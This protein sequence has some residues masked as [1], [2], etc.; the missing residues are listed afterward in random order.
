[1]TQRRLCC[2]LISDTKL[3]YSVGQGA[4]LINL[5][6]EHTFKLIPICPADVPAFGFMWQGKIHV[7]VICQ[8]A[9]QLNVLYL[10]I[11]QVL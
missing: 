2:M 6:I 9:A 1:M 8:L 7:N 3:T 10:N 11:L 5:D 4:T